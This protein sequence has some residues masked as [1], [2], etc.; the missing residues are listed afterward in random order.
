M[1]GASQRQ[2]WRITR[3]ETRLPPAQD[4]IANA[5][6]GSDPPVAPLTESAPATPWRSRDLIRPD[7]RHQF[8]IE[9]EHTTVAQKFSVSRRAQ[10]EPA[11]RSPGQGAVVSPASRNEAKATLILQI[12]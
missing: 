11:S 6:T 1:N 3:R 2:R 9:A 12:A 8:S 4:S 10:P 7:F 5:L